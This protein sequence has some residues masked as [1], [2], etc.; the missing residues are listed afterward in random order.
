LIVADMLCP[1]AATV[2]RTISTMLPACPS[3]LNINA[4]ERFMAEL[5]FLD[6]DFRPGIPEEYH[7][8]CLPWQ[9]RPHPASSLQPDKFPQ[10]SR[11]GLPPS[12]MLK[13][14]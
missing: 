4:F 2:E 5:L 6:S 14:L 8:T 13:L 9:P 7:V 3:F 11:T 10:R 1:C 12:G